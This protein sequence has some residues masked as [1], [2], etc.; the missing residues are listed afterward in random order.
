MILIDRKTSN[1]SVIIPTLNEEHRL[2]RL[3]ASLQA[4]AGVEIIVADGGSRDGTAAAA[5]RHGAVLA[6][7]RP[8]R[9]RQLR[10]GLRNASGEILLFLHCDTALPANFTAHVHATLNRPGTAAGAFRLAINAPG[11]KYRLVEW[12]AYFRSRWLELPFGDQAI[13]LRRQVLLSAGGMPEDPVMEDI[14]LVRRLKRV[15]RIR[16]APAAVVTSARR[17]QR[18]GVVRATLLNQVMLAGYILNIDRDRMYR[19]YYRHA[20]RHGPP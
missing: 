13:F 4:H 5:R 9:G 10:H 3:L 11:V 14:A 18:L 12:G 7:S 19:F 20:T 16:L 17:W 15:G 8:G 6:V 1:I 2:D